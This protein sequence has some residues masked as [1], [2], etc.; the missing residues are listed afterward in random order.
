MKSAYNSKQTCKFGYPTTKPDGT[1][2]CRKCDLAKEPVFLKNREGKCG[3]MVENKA[4]GGVKRLW[5]HDLKIRESKPGSEAGMFTQLLTYPDKCN[6]K[7]KGCGKKAADRICKDK[8]FT[9]AKGFEIWDRKPRN[10][11]HS[12][13]FVTEYVTGNQCKANSDGFTPT[14]CR[15]F[16]YI[17]CAK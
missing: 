17:D 13:F 7:N 5:A 8:G 2:L 4:E 10:P 11:L 15:T 6:R 12:E 16:Q 3:Y 9:K 14:V 1:R